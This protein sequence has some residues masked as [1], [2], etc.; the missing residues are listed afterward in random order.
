MFNNST[1]RST[2][3]KTSSVGLDPGDRH[4]L[5][6]IVDLGGRPDGTGSPTHDAGRFPAQV[7]RLACL[8]HRH[9]GR[10]PLPLGQPA[11]A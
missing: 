11:P 5:V 10:N 1:L 6:A 8:P 3:L 2:S 7:L 9:G 4:S